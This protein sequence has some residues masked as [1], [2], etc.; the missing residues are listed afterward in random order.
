MKISF[1]KISLIGIISLSLF[2]SASGQTKKTGK[3]IVE[4]T[5][6]EAIKQIISNGDV[7]LSVGKNCES[8]GTSPDDKTILDFLIGVLSFQAAPNSQNQ[9][10]FVFKQEKNLH[11]QIVW[12]CDL[13]FKGK[14]DEGVWDNGI[15]FKMLN[16]SRKLIRESISCIGAG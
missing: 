16:S 4:P 5:I 3:A 9:I 13:S 7:P 15:R 6:K 8:V 11:N 2:S 12:V 14:D 10:E 1:I